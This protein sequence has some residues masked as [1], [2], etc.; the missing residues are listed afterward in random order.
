MVLNFH[1]GTGSAS[2]QIIIT[3]MNAKSDSSGFIAVYPDG[4]GN[5]QAWNAGNC[6]G[7]A[8]FYNVDDVLFTRRIIEEMETEFC[9]D[10]KRVYACGHSNGAI[11][12]HRIA[13]ALSDKI[14]AIG[15]VGG[16]I[17]DVN[18]TDGTIYYNCSPSRPVSVVQL[19]GLQDGCYPYNGGVGGGITA[20]DFVS[21]PH[22]AADWVSRNGCAGTTVQTYASGNA[23]CVSYKDGCNNGS[24][25]MVCTDSE[26][27]HCWLG[28]SIYPSALICGG[29]TTT[30]ISANDIIWSFF[31]SHPMP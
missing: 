8:K 29:E 21:I 1:G 4:Y 6:C 20:A 16:G 28:S 3:G 7:E 22:T 27:G 2:N 25:V 30:D 5:T 24:E 31:L 10:P 11:M 18:P 15:A 14:A 12:T 19:H 9:I 13:C 26:A 23:V 17:G